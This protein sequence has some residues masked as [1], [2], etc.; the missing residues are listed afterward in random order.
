M[1]AT[2]N[3]V[4]MSLREAYEALWH[5]GHVGGFTWMA[6]QFYRMDG[7]AR[8]QVDTHGSRSALAVPALRT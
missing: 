2:H 6:E 3:P 7:P 8:R 4:A 1:L 5:G